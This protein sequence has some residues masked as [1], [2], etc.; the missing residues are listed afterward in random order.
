MLIYNG[1]LN[2][3]SN[4]KSHSFLQ[5]NSC[6]IQST[7]S[8]PQIVYRQKGRHDYLINYIS[9]GQC[10]V[11]YNG[12]THVLREGLV[13]HPP[14]TPQKYTDH[15]NTT[16][17]WVHFNG[18]N[19]EEIL[20]EA[21]LQGGIYHIASPMLEKMFLQL[22]AEHHL[23]SPISN[24][25]GLLLSILYTVGKMVNNTDSQNS[26][27]NDAVA[28]I[29]S[30]YNTD[31]SIQELAASCHISQSH[32]ISLFKKQTGMAPHVYQ[33]TLRLKNAMS[34]LVSTQLS[35]SDICTMSG[36]Q[37]PLYFSRLF[38]KQTGM[39]PMAYRKK[40]SNAF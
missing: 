29:T 31:I 16:R 6:G 2:N 3:T 11:E 39:S 36:Y 23:S 9:D 35:I 28:F 27:I 33:K 32:F 22:I 30:H 34:L 38:R 8:T 26:K 7:F 5:I 14:Y 19:I 13:L 25:K 40:N 12:K 17:M 37:D 21:N 10:D 1:D 18:Y 20:A 24:E 15:E 4:Y